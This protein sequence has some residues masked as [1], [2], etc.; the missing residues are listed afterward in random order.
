VVGG[1][2]EYLRVAALLQDAR[3]P[4]QLLGFLS[5]RPAD[6]AGAQYLGTPGQLPQVA[7][8]YQVEELIFSGK[9]LT[10]A[11]IMAW[12]VQ[13]NRHDLQYKILPEGSACIIGSHSKKSRGDYYVLP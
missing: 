6:Q 3:V 2:Q 5:S 11:E 9:D 8:R 4:A 12:M 7:Q 13:W 1:Q 10:A